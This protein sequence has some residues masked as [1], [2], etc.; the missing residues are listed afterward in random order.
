MK[1][2]ISVC[3]F[4]CAVTASGYSIEWKSPNGQHIVKLQQEASDSI[5]GIENPITHTSYEVLGNSVFRRENHGYGW[6]QNTQPQWLNDR[7]LIF[8][9]SNGLAIVDA[10]TEK[11]LI[12]SVFTGF[13]K[14]PSKNEWV[15]IRFR[16]TTKQQTFLAGDEED[17]L[18]FL[19]PEKISASK[20]RS[21]EMDPFQY[22]QQTKPGGII[23]APPSWSDDGAEV[24]ILSWKNGDVTGITYNATNGDILKTLPIPVNI[25][26]EL[27]LSPWF[28]NEL[29]AIVEQA[30]QDAGLLSNYTPKPGPPATAAPVPQGIKSD[31]PKFTPTVRL[32]PIPVEPPNSTH[33]DRKISSSFLVIPV[34]ALF[35]VLIG[36]IVFLIRRKS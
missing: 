22:I 35:A 17:V 11:I 8:Q 19:N 25:P 20:I 34:V 32:S 30:V 14:S 24:A 23:L 26:N 2:F 12:N 10:V 31:I 21:S 36:L 13:S 3:L 15:A 29:T 6:F 7:F 27:A 18:L 1:S 9:D 4:M 33:S 16:P 28:S 5:T